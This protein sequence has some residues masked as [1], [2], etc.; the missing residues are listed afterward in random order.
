MSLDSEVNSERAV[1][2]TNGP[3][4]DKFM[5]SQGGYL[6]DGIHGFNRY[7]GTNLKSLHL[8]LQMLQNKC[9]DMSVL[10]ELEHGKLGISLHCILVSPSL[11]LIVSSFVSFGGRRRMMEKPII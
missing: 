1:S 3:H 7:I 11:V 6:K 4:Q 8:P 10:G 5:A 9:Y 2:I